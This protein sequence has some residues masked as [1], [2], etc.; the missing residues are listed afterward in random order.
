VAIFW[1]YQEIKVVQ[2]YT[3]QKVKFFMN[4]TMLFLLLRLQKKNI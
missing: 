2:L 3:D 1:Y 4:G